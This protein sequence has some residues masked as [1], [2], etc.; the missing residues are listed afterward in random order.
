M[1]ELLDDITADPAVVDAAVA[2]VR[3]DVADLGRLPADDIARHTRALLVAAVRALA[4]RRGPTDAELAFTESLAV[5]RAR[6]QVPI[7]SV[8]T[9]V[10]VATRQVWLHARALAAG[11]DVPLETLVDARDLLDDWA[12]QVRARLI[13]A[14][15][16]AELAHAASARD[17]RVALLRRALEGGAAGAAAVDDAG[18]PARVWVV[19]AEPDDAARAAS[20]EAALITGPG[21]LVASLDGALVGVLGGPP[22]APTG[23]EVVG[24]VGPVAAA[25]VAV[26]ARWARWSHRAAVAEGLRGLVPLAA[27]P[28]AAA[29]ASRPELAAHL[30]GA[31]DPL[32]DDA[33]ARALAVTV[34][35]HVGTGGRVEATAAA[36]HVHPNTVRHRLRRFTETTGLALDLP[37]EAV[38]AAW[39]LRHR[40]P[41]LEV[42]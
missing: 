40:W 12:E 14:H 27:V 19:H 6:Q 1:V 22:R 39:L 16:D 10:H 3:R 24:C 18:L 30:A 7:A 35:T 17:R 42:P 36:L 9:A 28:V 5:A 38:A 8:L 11:R 25:E 34:V 4:E 29:L 20:L 13:V 31:L 2:A 32:G 41:D 26:A 21:D 23:P 15:R 33:F 37:Q